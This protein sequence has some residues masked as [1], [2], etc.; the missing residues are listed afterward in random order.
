MSDTYPCIQCFEHCSEPCIQCSRC[1]RWVHITCVP[2]TESDLKSWDNHLL[3]FYCKQCCY[4]GIDFDSAESL[5]RYVCLNRV[6]TCFQHIRFLIYHIRY[7]ICYIR[8]V[9]YYI[10]YIS[11]KISDILFY[12][13]F[14]LNKSDSLFI[15]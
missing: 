5:A 13:F 8:Y 15:Y 3:N 11:H 2:M 9:T 4:S 14:Y 12:I 7:L 6:P 10:R 1:E